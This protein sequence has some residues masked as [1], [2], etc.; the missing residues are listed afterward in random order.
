MLGAD[1]EHAK[2]TLL[3]NPTMI[4]M[5][6]VQVSSVCEGAEI[7]ASRGRSFTPLPK[8]L[9]LL[10]VFALDEPE[11]RTPR[12]ATF[13]QKPVDL[14]VS[15]VPGK[16]KLSFVSDDKMCKGQS[17]SI[18]STLS[19]SDAFPIYRRRYFQLYGKSSA[20]FRK[21]LYL[22]QLTNHT[23]MIACR[24]SGLCLREEAR[25]RK[26]ERWHLCRLQVLNYHR[27]E[28]RHGQKELGLR[29]GKCCGKGPAAPCCY[30]GYGRNSRYE[31]CTRT[32]TC[33]ER[34]AFQN[35]RYDLGG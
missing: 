17:A 14:L 1:D 20:C 28:S 2:L 16:W 25:W 33:D 27:R 19:L 29:K 35:T 26:S 10:Q 9:M 6:R 21:L 23:A 4:A 32:R 7:K 13:G 24:F 31:G 5:T 34:P 3:P 15:N 30:Y 8:E 18:S 22:L 12:T 11:P